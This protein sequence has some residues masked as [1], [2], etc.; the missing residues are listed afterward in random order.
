M[1]NPTTAAERT[2]LN[3]RKNEKELKITST[4]NQHQRSL[5]KHQHQYYLLQKGEKKSFSIV[6]TIRA[7]KAPNI[8][9]T[10]VSAKSHYFNNPKTR[11]LNFQL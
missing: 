8:S 2:S 10:G 4:F 6:D 11:L 3:K 7:I 1:I 5:C 9:N